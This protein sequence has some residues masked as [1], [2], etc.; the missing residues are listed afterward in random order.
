MNLATSRTLAAIGAVLA[1][2]TLA[3]GFARGAWFGTVHAYDAAE[4]GAPAAI[5][6]PRDPQAALAAL[7]AHRHWGEYRPP[8]TAER[9]PA[10]EPGVAG[11]AIARDFLLV[12]IRGDGPRRQALLLPRGDAAAAG[13]AM[14]RLR[15][16]D[17]L[18]DGVRVEAVGN[19]SVRL[20]AGDTT[21]TLHLYGNSP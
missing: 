2:L 21:L 10:A 7:G 8:A 4:A 19:A 11:N 13:D 18:I 15:A 1:A 3:G 17:A 20:R 16:G 5:A 12:G 6:A 9:A 14:I